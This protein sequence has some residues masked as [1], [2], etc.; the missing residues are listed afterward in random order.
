MEEPVQIQTQ[1]TKQHQELTDK[2][3]KHQ[4]RKSAIKNT[5]LQITTVTIVCSLIGLTAPE[6]HIGVWYII[7]GYNIIMSLYYITKAYIFYF[8]LKIDLRKYNKEIYTG[9]VINNITKIKLG[10]EN[11]VISTKN[12]TFKINKYTNHL[13]IEPD[14]EY[15][16]Y[17]INDTIIGL[18]A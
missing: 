18:F 9:K 10:L 12:T 14:K 17:K 3:L 13:Q 2:E 15:T 7:I 16:I 1:E 6:S 8:R 4:I 5:I 11:P